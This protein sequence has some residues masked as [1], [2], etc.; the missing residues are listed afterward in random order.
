MIIDSLLGIIGYLS[1]ILVSESAGVMKW[2]PPLPLFGE[3]CVKIE[4]NPRV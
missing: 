1:L 2:L 3:P 4:K